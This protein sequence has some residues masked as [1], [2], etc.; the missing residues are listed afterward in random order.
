L[1]NHSHPSETA[2]LI[3]EIAF[4]DRV[5]AGDDLNQM[6]DRL[7][8]ESGEF[9]ARSLTEIT[10]KSPSAL[11]LAVELFR[12][13]RAITNL[14]DALELE[15]AAARA[16]VIGP[17]FYEGI[18]AAIIDKDRNPR[19]SPARIADVPQG[20]AAAAL[21]LTNDRVFPKGSTT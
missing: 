3:D 9:A 8:G 2:P 20:W 18:R 15:F 1:A 21:Q 19:W 12:R 11:V 16:L 14:K 10:A 5:F 17:D 6:L 7:A 13:G 4:I